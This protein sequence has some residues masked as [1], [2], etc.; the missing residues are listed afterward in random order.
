MHPQDGRVVSNFIVQALKGADITIYGDGRQ[1]RSFC[2][3][4]DL[5]EAMLR[6]MDTPPNFTG[7]KN[8]G[9][10]GE[11]TVIELAQRVLSLT[12]SRSKL[13][14][15]PLPSDDPRQ[16]QPDISLAKSTIG[17]TPKVDLEDGLK[18]TIAYFRKLLVR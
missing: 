12:G 17:W 18:E 3:V 2:Y 14:F 1:T 4:D 13:V 6:T 16:R 9:N 7:P 15:Q 11:F 5:V 10:L 8:L